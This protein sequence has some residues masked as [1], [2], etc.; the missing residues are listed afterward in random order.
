MR[1]QLN[2][3]GVLGKAAYLAG[4]YDSLGLEYPVGALVEHLD[5]GGLWLGGLLDTSRSGLS[6]PLRLVSVAYE[7]WSGPLS[8]FFPGNTP[9][10]SFWVSAV[11]QPV[12]PGWD[13]YW[14]GSLPYSPVSDQDLSC[15]YTDTA[16]GIVGHVPMRMKVIQSS[17]VWRDPPHRPV[18]V[19]EYRLMNNGSKTI[20]SLYVGFFLEGVIRWGSSPIPPIGYP[21]PNYSWYDEE[22]R[23]AFRKNPLYPST[24]PIGVRLIASS[25]PLDS[26]RM[27]FR[28]FEGPQTP[29]TDAAKYAMLSSGIIDSAGYSLPGGHDRA[30][31]ACGPFTVRPFG[32]P[33]ADTIKIAFAIV[34]G[35][36][37]T[38]MKNHS[39]RAV[40]LFERHR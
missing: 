20:D 38:E 30:V 35:Q 9:A 37:I 23:L 19:L 25:R 29:G 22:L 8:E 12:P 36:N 6:T 7:G 40:E 2:N 14:G 1:L 39:Q 18:V 31:L 27:T 4:G 13:D 11:G 32:D 5:G 15:I 10:D 3:K 17:Y 26:L 16:S 24:T 21:I 34:S 28:I 33:N